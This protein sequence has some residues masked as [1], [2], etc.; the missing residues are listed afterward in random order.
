[1]ANGIRKVVKSKRRKKR[2]G[3]MMNQPTRGPIPL[4]I[5]FNLLLTYSP[6]A[7]LGQ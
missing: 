2:T 5:C 6:T 7:S 4:K 3:R 1:M